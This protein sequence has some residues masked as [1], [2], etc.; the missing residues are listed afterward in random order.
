MSGYENMK[1]IAIV[2]PSTAGHH[3]TYTRIFARTVLGRGQ[4]VLAIVPDAAGL[5]AWV[6]AQCPAAAPNLRAVELGVMPNPH[7]PAML[8]VLVGKASW[9]R[10]VAQRIRATG[11]QPDLV[12]HTW[13]DNCLTPGLSAGV[14]DLIFP[15]TWSGLYFHPWYLRTQLRFAGL[16]QGPLAN[17]SAL[18]SRRCPAVAVLD[19]GIAPL[20][21]ARLH[22]P[23]IV[24]PDIAD[25]SE[26]DAAYAP[27]QAIRRRAQGRTVVGLLGALSQR[28]GVM[29]LLDMLASAPARDWF[30]VLAGELVVD[31]F[32]PAE[33]ARLAALAAAP[34]ENCLLHFQRIPDEPQFNALVVACDSLF[35][36]YIH[37]LS[38][39][40]LLTKAALFE[41]PIV[42]SAGYCMGERVAR[43]G[44]GRA[45]PAADPDAALAALAEITALVQRHGT[46]PGADYA[47]YRAA[48]SPAQLEESFGKLLAAAG[49]PPEQQLEQQ[50]EQP[51]ET[52]CPSPLPASF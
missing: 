26:P 48:H 40:N 1:T 16:R 12:F 35:A 19:E 22:K 23:V 9:V 51:P 15:Y 6:E 2:A 34:P 32:T 18:R 36:A 20:L 5:T 37:F 39:S 27:A 41:K 21:Q 13:L 14:T 31:S 3:Q 25:D 28:K 46:L 45:V 30:F 50:P 4:R 38:S 52:V 49:L 43:Y 24:F 7:A 47:G 33:Q 29:T 8:Q 11:E 42:V 10:F 44:I 17:H